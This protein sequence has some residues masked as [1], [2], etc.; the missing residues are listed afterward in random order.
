MDFPAR[1]QT[2]G[3]ER[4]RGFSHLYSPLQQLP[5]THETLTKQWQMKSTVHIL[6]FSSVLSPGFLVLSPYRTYLSLPTV[7]THRLTTGHVPAPI[8][9]LRA[10]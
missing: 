6:A 3:T 7:V 4:T 2:L 10:Y 9:G 8:H 1:L 5:D